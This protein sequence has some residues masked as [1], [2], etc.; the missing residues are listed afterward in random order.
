LVPFEPDRIAQRLF[1]A[2]SDSGR[3]DAFLAHELAGGVLHFLAHEYSA[4]PPTTAEISELMVKVVSGLGHPD[5]ARR[6]SALARSIAEPDPLQESDV[7]GS[8]PRDIL[9]AH[10]DGLLTLT[11]LERPLELAGSVLG[12]ERSVRVAVEAAREHTGQWVSI[13]GPD[14]AIAGGDGEPAALAEEFVRELR[15]G[16]RSTGLSAVINLNQ[17]DP[18]GWIRD[19]GGGPLFGGLSPAAKGERLEVATAVLLRELTL[20]PA[21]APS[22]EIAWHIHS[23][24]PGAA[25]SATLRQ[26]VPFA[27]AGQSIHFVLDRPRDPHTLG[28]G[29]TRRQR[30]VLLVVGID[31]S[32]LVDQLPVRTTERFVTKLGTLARL[33]R[34]AGHAKQSLLRRRGR[35]ALTQGFLLDRARL[36]LVPIDLDDAVQKLTGRPPAEHASAV[37]FAL[38]I[39]RELR[40]T[41]NDDRFSSLQTVLELAPCLFD[42][43][44]K[45]VSVDTSS[46][47]DWKGQIVR[48]GR[49]HAAADGGIVTIA[50]RVEESRSVDRLLSVL[51][52]AATQTE[53]HRLRVQSVRLPANSHPV[54][55]K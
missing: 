18:P 41:L 9:S 40:A 37:D 7:A 2:L 27:A 50:L 45:A 20:A 29:L 39:Q 3:P 19:L 31:L 30:S 16:L 42:A 21:G 28:I 5:L 43:S 17:A 10:R 52:Y 47:L 24:D 44:R 15:S 1:L 4:T 48:I 6:L 13:D 33:A 26:A 53:V 51:D 14:H 55:Q 46:T 12:P 38:R 36:V 8:F 11:G 54:T 22:V 49:L 23:A 34:S 32:R 35:E 25:H